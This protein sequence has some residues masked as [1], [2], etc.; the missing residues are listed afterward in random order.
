MSGGWCSSIYIWNEFSKPE[1]YAID[2]I[3]NVH[4]WCFTSTA[5]ASWTESLE[6]CYQALWRLGKFYLCIYLQRIYSFMLCNKKIKHCNETF[7]LMM[8]KVWLCFIGS[9]IAF[10]GFTS[11]FNLREKNNNRTIWDILY[12]RWEYVITIITG[13]G[14]L[15]VY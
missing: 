7:W 12:R 6:S 11:I 3:P 8:N 5:M 2:A 13:Q 10:I 4:W 15:G 1:V 9:T 14:I